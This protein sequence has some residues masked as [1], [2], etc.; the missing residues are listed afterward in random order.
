MKIHAYQ[1]CMSIYFDIDIPRLGYWRFVGID[2][3]YFDN[4][5]ILCWR[6][7]WYW[8]SWISRIHWYPSRRTKAYTDIDVL[9]Y[10]VDVLI[11]LYGPCTCREAESERLS[12]S[13]LQS[14]V[15]YWVLMAVRVVFFPVKTMPR[16]G[17]GCTAQAQVALGTPP[18]RACSAPAPASRQWWSDHL[19]LV[20]IQDIMPPFTCRTAHYQ[21]GS[22]VMNSHCSLAR[23]TVWVCKCR[24]DIPSPCNEKDTV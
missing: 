18:S 11:D 22:F 16:P 4:N 12:G 1:W 20:F 3:L 23:V 14:A 19:L 6:F 2:G 24:L 9:H 8:G 13:L 21:E 15:L 10:D 17:G 7:I 5:S